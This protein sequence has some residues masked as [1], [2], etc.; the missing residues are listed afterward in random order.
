[1]DIILEVQQQHLYSNFATVNRLLQVMSTFYARSA[2]EVIKLLP[3]LL[4]WLSE[5][6]DLR[7]VSEILFMIIR[8]IWPNSMYPWLIKMKCPKAQKIV[9]LFLQTKQLQVLW[10]RHRTQLGKLKRW[11]AQKIGRLQFFEHAGMVK[12]KSLKAQ[13]EHTERLQAFHGRHQTELEFFEHTKRSQA[14]HGPH[15]T[16]LGRLKRSQAKG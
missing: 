8:W 16:K 11:K 14:F 6:C 3:W 1:M 4:L 12:M 7:F 10:G 2:M 9:R 15:R 13:N 5:E